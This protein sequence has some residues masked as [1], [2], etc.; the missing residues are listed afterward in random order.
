VYDRLS[1]ALATFLEGLTA[2]HD[3]NFF[4]DEA[5]RLGNPLRSTI[6]GSPFNQGPALEA[7][8]PIIRTNRKCG[9]PI[10]GFDDTE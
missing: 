9:F 7:T 5:R 6:R 3:G 8:H 4:H 1:P 2:T 10:Q